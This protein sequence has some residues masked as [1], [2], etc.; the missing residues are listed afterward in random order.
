LP[1]GPAA[2]SQPAIAFVKSEW[3]IA[4]VAECP[5]SRRMLC[6]SSITQFACPH[7][8]HGDSIGRRG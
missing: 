3:W 7:S 4:T 2:G 5:D 1:D 6:P 8:A